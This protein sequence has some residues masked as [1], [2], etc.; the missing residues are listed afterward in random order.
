[1][2][3]TLLAG[4]S[5]S[6]NIRGTNS[7]NGGSPLVLVDGVEGD[8]DRVNPNDIESISVIKDSSAA[9]IITCRKVK[10]QFVC[11]SGYRNIVALQWFLVF[12]Q[13]LPPIRIGVV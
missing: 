7:I 12:E 6:F 3:V 4:L 13:V 1:M 2:C 8:L 10:F 11:S 9:A 5:T